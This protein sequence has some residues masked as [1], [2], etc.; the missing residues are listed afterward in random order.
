MRISSAYLA[1]AVSLA[2][3]SCSAGLDVTIADSLCKVFPDGTGLESASL[4]V[5]IAA[6]ENASVQFVVRA[7]GE[8]IHDLT[9]SSVGVR[10][11]GMKVRSA[12]PVLLVKN[13]YYE[14]WDRDSMAYSPADFRFPDPIVCDSTAFVPDGEC[15]SL[16]LDIDVAP[17]T[18]PGTY[19]VNVTITSSEGCSR[20]RFKIKVYPVSIS[21]QRLLVTNWM[22]PDYHFLNG[23]DWPGDSLYTALKADLYKMAGEYGNN[24]WRIMNGARA[25]T[26]GKGNTIGWDFRDFDAEVE[27]ILKN[28]PVAQIHGL[29]FGGRK[30][31]VGHMNFNGKPADD[32]ELKKW[33]YSFFPALQKHLEEKTLPDGRCWID[34]FAQF[35]ADEPIDYCLAD[36]ESVARM[37]KDAAPEIRTI[38]AYRSSTWDRSLLDYPCP[39]LDEFAERDIFQGVGRE[40]N[41]WFYTCMFPRNSYANR[42]L[43]QQLIKPRLLHWINYRYNAIGYLHWG[44]CYWSACN[45][46]P[47]G[48][49]SNRA[50]DWPGGDSHIVYPGYR[51]FYPSIRYCAMR[52]GIKDYELLRMVED[53]S[54]EKAEE[55]VRR[56]VLDY[57]RYDTDIKAFRAVRHEMLEYLSK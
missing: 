15:R 4:P 29:H 49:V 39:Q 30:E 51:R 41:V 35:I 50:N 18:K 54:P 13:S 26:D 9:I 46:D 7:K 44:L 19:P 42:F 8:D 40:D 28:A 17:D 36:W 45:G 55:L 53:K 22:E 48:E 12:G 56:I 57:N 47:Y 5:E 14:F 3:A 11:P 27:M 21:G 6:G 10:C 16:W 34:I 43:E 52:D 33:I 37:I 23:G 20:Q 31:W 24:C 1:L 38:E 2:L 25:L 32:P